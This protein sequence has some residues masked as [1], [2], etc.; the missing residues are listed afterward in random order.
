[1]VERN[2]LHHQGSSKCRVVRVASYIEGNR[3]MSCQGQAQP[4]S[5]EEGNRKQCRWSSGNRWPWQGQ[6]FQ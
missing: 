3:E 6:L 4:V 5:H 2:I 1:M